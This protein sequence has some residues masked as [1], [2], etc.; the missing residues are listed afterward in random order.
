MPDIY[1]IYAN[2]RTHWFLAWLAASEGT[3]LQTLG[4]IRALYD[5]SC[6]FICDEI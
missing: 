4:S 6:Q 2:I 1:E 3:R 5:T